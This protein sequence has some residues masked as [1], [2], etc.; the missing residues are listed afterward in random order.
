MLGTCRGA[1]GGV[2][3]VATAGS[4]KGGVPFAITGTTS[5]PKFVPDVGGV[6]GGVATGAV[7][8]AAKAPGTAV[9]AP[10]KAVGGLVSKKSN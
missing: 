3:K 2:T 8:E 1:V 5:D 9:S 4:G 7:K 10:T 6:V